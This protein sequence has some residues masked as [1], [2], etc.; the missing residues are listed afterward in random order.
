MLKVFLSHASFDAEI[1]A[2]LKAEIEG[3]VKGIDVFVS[4]DP[5]DLPPG[6][7]WPTE[8]QRA[9]QESQVLLLLATTRSMG[10]PWVWFEAGT[11]WFRNIPLIP[12]C[13]G[14]V[15]KNALPPP[16][17]ERQ[18]LNVDDPSD[19]VALLKRLA[20]IAGSRVEDQEIGLIIGRL[21]D[22][23][24]KAANIA[25][26]GPAGWLG[27]EW[28]GRFL[29][30]DGPIE[31]LRLIEDEAV[32]ESMVEALEAQG[33]QTR[34]G[35]PDKLGK[36]AEKG[37]RIIYLTDRKSWRRKI[38]QIDTILIARPTTT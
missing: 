38:T 37:Y 12:L 32:Q 8:I 4:S 24:Q 25:A 33:Y 21:M 31:G 3:R 14:D 13:V 17:S 2:L 28:K 30:Y 19:I 18:A 15:R 23:E 36:H 7:V 1:A 6:V 20:E 9:L 22:L 11:V 10:R 16:V 5:S 29:A 26:A 27:A 34:L 35:R